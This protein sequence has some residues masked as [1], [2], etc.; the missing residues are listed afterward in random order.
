MC[1]VFTGGKPV[2]YILTKNSGIVW[3]LGFDKFSWEENTHTD[4]RGTDSPNSVPGTVLR[5]FILQL[6]YEISMIII[7]KEEYILEP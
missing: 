1:W 5:A 7:S 2:Y 4:Q 6:L 3:S